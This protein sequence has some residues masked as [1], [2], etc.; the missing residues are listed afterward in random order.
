MTHTALTR[1]NDVIVY[2]VKERWLV[3]VTSFDQWKQRHL[4]INA[5]E[6]GR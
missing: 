1:E 2:L 3:S 5:V 4:L 6:F